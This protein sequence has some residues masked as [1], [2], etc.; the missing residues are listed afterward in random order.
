MTEGPGGW[1]GGGAVSEGFGLGGWS[2]GDF[3]PVVVESDRWTCSEFVLVVEFD[4]FGSMGGVVS[5][6]V[7]ASTFEDR[8]SVSW[9]LARSSRRVCSSSFRC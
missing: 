3:V 2:L 7:D 8:S 5:L 9:F 1:V 6:A 4:W